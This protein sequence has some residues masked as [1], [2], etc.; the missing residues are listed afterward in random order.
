[1]SVA[2]PEQPAPAT[3]ALIPLVSIRQH[4]R[5]G[6]TVALGSMPQLVERQTLTM[7]RYDALEKL[8]NQHITASAL[9]VPAARLHQL[10]QAHSPQRL[11]ARVSPPCQHIID[12]RGGR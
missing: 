4:Y 2:A 11:V 12:R 9:S 3:G 10:F 7:G 6:L 5:V 8:D 1:M